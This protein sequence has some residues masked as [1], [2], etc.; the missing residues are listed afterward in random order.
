MAGGS[1]VGGGCGIVVGMEGATK[2]RQPHGVGN[3][4]AECAGGG[5]E[6]GADYCAGATTG[7]AGGSSW[8]VC[9]VAVVV[10]VSGA[11][12]GS[13]HAQLAGGAGGDV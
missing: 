5:G 11:A 12:R 1:A 10:G 8:H 13:S 2:S 7:D 4:A 9:G 6:R 3:G